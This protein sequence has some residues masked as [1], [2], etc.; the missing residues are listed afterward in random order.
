[1]TVDLGSLVATGPNTLMYRLVRDRLSR[2]LPVVCP[3]SMVVINQLDLYAVYEFLRISNAR[4][5]SETLWE[6]SGER[7]ERVRARR[8][9][10][11][12]LGDVTCQILSTIR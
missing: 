3:G 1:M 7:H 12:L 8:G 6:D 9:S 4:C 10:S 2:S 5:R 11:A